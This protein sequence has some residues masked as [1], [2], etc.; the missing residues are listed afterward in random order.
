MLFPH[1]AEIR[2]PA[3]GEISDCGRLVY[4]NN[5]YFRKMYGK[6]RLKIIFPLLCFCKGRKGDIRRI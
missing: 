1:G 6:L 3:V 4:K 2:K 5:R